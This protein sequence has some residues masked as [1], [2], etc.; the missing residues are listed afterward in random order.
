M[1]KKLFALSF[2]LSIS[3]VGLAQTQKP[4]SK[5]DSLLKV[6]RKIADTGDAIE[7]KK[8][9]TEIARLLKS[10]EEKIL[11]LPFVWRILSNKVL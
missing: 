4:L 6:Y 5:E 8:V 1:F 2:L 11:P 10:S 7:L 9:D 3:L